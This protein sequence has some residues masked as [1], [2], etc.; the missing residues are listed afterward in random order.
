[1][2]NINSSNTNNL[3]SSDTITNM[4]IA[5]WAGPNYNE[6]RSL[7][8]G[9]IDFEDF[10]N[11]SIDNLI[12]ALSVFRDQYKDCT[13]MITKNISYDVA[14]EHIEGYKAVRMET[15]QE[16]EKRINGYK[17]DIARKQIESLENKRKMYEEFKTLFG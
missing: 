16:I 8:M 6:A 14:L 4:Q 7:V 17:K 15:D 11:Q 3:D 9:S 5:C 1:M 2:V 12:Q 13:I 10:E